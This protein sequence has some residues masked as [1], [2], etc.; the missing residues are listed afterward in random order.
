MTIVTQ[1]MDMMKA[2][3][4]YAQKKKWA[5][6]PLHTVNE[7]GMCS[8]RK[9]DCE[10]AGKHPRWD[11]EL[12]P[13]GVKGA[14]TDM[15]KIIQWWTKWPDANIGVATG[16]ASGFIVLDIDPPLGEESIEEI[17][18]AHG[19]LPD[20][21]EAITGSGGRH[22]LFKQPSWYVK[23]SSGEIGKGLDVR[24]D[25]GYIVV[26][27]SL[28]KSGQR[29]EWEIEHRPEET[30][31]AEIPEWLADKLQEKVTRHSETA[32]AQ[33]TGRVWRRYLKGGAIEEGTRDNTLFAIGCSMRANGASY[34][35][36]LATLVAVNAERC[37]PPMEYRQVLQKAD[38]AAKY[39]P[40][41]SGLMEF[42]PTDWGNA[43]RLADRHGAD[44][45]FCG[46][47]GGWYIW[48]GKRWAKDESGEIYRRAAET[49]R[50][51]GKE[52][53]RQLKE[54]EKQYKQETDTRKQEEL[55]KKAK[56][57]A[58]MAKFAKQSESR[59]RLESMITLA[60][61]IPGIPVAV[62]QWDNDPWLINFENGTFDIKKGK[63]RDHKREDL[64]TK[65]IPVEYNEEAK[66]PRWT[67][68][69]EEIMDGD[70]ELIE[71]LQKSIGY[72]LTG[73]TQ[74][75]VMFLL[76]G[77]GANGK[78][79]FLNVIK[80]MMG[81]YGQQAPTSLLMAKKSD[82]VPN[83][84]A[85]L[86]GARYI[87][88]IETEKGK[89]LAEALVKQLTGGDMITARFLRQ[90]FFEFKPEGK[91]FLATNHKPVISGDD[92]AIWRRIRLIPFEV[93][94]PEEK[95]DPLLE[96]KLHDELPGILCWA[97]EGLKKWMKE[98]LKAPEKVLAATDEYR[99]SMDNLGMFIDECCVL[100]PN[101]KT[102]IKKL[103]EAY[104]QWALDNGLHPMGNPQLRER[105]K[106]RGFQQK[107]TGK[108]GRFWAGIG[109]IEEQAFEKQAPQPYKY[110]EYPPEHERTTSEPKRGIR[111]M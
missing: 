47:L 94:I 26:A 19:P 84:V 89:R 62:E 49:V 50:E 106:E 96:Y 75:Q 67:S 93:T 107:R 91:F 9:R 63:L 45:K 7:R 59:P 87:T 104:N 46:K 17:E 61:N 71:F 66:A 88:T 77:S 1:N 97:I 101:A 33:T 30:E 55:E 92:S 58:G 25:G 73:S 2:A 56:A 95:R 65:I 100:D 23:S 81:D 42:P 5:V 98:G 86:K 6:F 82:G 83:D 70:Q 36:I 57:L 103:Y 40:G 80:E 22:I 68:F 39:S 13:N 99:E 52:A 3:L 64:I 8:C 109:L 20:T 90:E 4:W 24:G 12:L 111:Y 79:V 15:E 48:D 10:N 102:P 108:L 37:N 110:E 85:R 31:L 29:Y 60:Q 74:E 11:K 51:Y 28:H 38:Q 105:L 18:R 54:I 53:N 76:H 43:E 78:S 32:K 14:S 69:L 27:P 41:R 35:D 34:E 72:S 44:I 21:I 16:A